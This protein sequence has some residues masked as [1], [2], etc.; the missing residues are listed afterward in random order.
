M[1]K[2]TSRRATVLVQLGLF[3]GVLLFLN[4]LSNARFSGK[5]LYA[6][7]DLTEEGRFTLTEGSRNLMRELDD[8][9][10]VNVLLE[11]NFPAGFKRLQ[12]AA[13]ELLDDL[14]S[15][16]GYIEYDFEDP[17]EGSTEEVNERRK[18][19]S[20]D[21]IEPIN[22]KVKEKDGSSQQL[23]Y[24]Y[25]ICYYK[26]RSIAVNLLENEVPGVPPEVVLNNSVRLLEFKFAS[27]IKKLKEDAR[28]II[29]F[30]TGHGELDPSET[31]DLEK[32]LRQFYD[33][34][35]IH[36]DSL[37]SI[38]TDASILI[39]AKPRGPFS[40][41][42]KFKLDQY[43]MNG[44]KIIWMLDKVRVDLDSLQ[45]KKEYFPSEYDLNLEDLLFQYGVRL[46]PDMVLD[47]Q[48]SP[49]PLTTGPVGAN[50]N[51]DLFPYP[52]HIVVT[53]R[54][55]HPI[56]KSLGPL[57]LFYAGSIK[58]DIG[59]ST[60]VKRTTL[61][62]S[63]PYSRFQF[64]PVGMDLNFA[65]YELDASKFDKGAQN[66][67]VLLEGTF[68]SMFKNRVNADMLSGLEQI[69]VAFKSQSV[70][71][72]MV[73][74]SD[75][76]LIK[77]KIK[78]SPQGPYILPPGFNEF[79]RAYYA[80]KDFVLNTIEYLLGDEGF[81]EARG[82]EVKLRLLDQNKV[83]TWKSRIQALN[84]LVPLAFFGIFAAVFLFVRKRRFAK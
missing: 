60:D 51:T 77:N 64:L 53:P 47:M 66:L 78:Q 70:P 32:T 83:D 25:A 34:G 57:N 58:S 61:L 38:S 10:Y 28:P 27:A 15:E 13:R 71:T 24:P 44:G 48:C 62:E 20:K 42:D 55:E 43:V 45:G 39:V 8:V 49:I 52:Y 63:S 1:S 30:T 14:R 22:L 56:A 74:V 82:K 75:G 29:A 76:D 50:R 7:F 72:A 80:N 12:G 35:R 17:S 31:Y 84:I 18:E 36:L 19:L 21:K 46:E 11:G 26:G 67:A 16:S 41:K 81:I 40:E 33:T 6:Q 54:T 65:R 79:N 37:I 4:I 69:G 5:P 9:V 59:V 23:I 68:P 3:A 2:Q 73:V